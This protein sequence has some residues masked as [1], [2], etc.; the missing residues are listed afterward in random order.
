M[1]LVWTII[2]KT[3]SDIWSESFLLI[4]FNVIWVLGSAPGLLLLAYGAITRAV[5]LLLIGFITIIPWP[6]LTFS[7]F[8]MAYEVGEG[9]AIGFRRFFVLGRQ[10][11]R[12]AYLWGGMNLVVIPILVAN[13]SFYSNPDAP[14]G[15]NTIGTVVSSFFISI[16]IFWMVL[17][18][19]ALTVYPRLEKPG[20]RN[21][22][23]FA[24]QII[25][26]WPIPALSATFISLCFCL[27]SFFIPI[28]PI[29]I[30]FSF[31]AVLANRAMAEILAEDS[32]RKGDKPAGT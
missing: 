20:I 30:T 9:K 7:L 17:Q 23:S 10:V 27:I 14:W 25:L 12:Q 3:F 1:S 16:A 6:F 8:H 31:I 19:F 5:L 4:L 22:L 18:E 26:R 15:G 29:L 32:R 13:I 24:A 21:T 28:L 11:W 2:R